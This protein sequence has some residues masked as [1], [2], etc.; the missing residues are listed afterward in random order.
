HHRTSVGRIRRFQGIPTFVGL[1]ELSNFNATV[2]CLSSLV[3]VPFPT[4]PHI[5]NVAVGTLLFTE[6]PHT[7]RICY[8]FI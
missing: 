8:R 5:H 1:D 7:L 2:S 6:T 3:A 4:S